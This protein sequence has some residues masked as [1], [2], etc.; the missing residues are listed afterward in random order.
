MPVKKCVD[1]KILFLTYKALHDKAPAYISDML[2]Y[3]EGRTFWSTQPNLLYV[4][5]TKCVTFGDRAFSV[6]AP[7]EWNKL[8]LEIRNLDTVDKFKAAIKHIRNKPKSP[9][10]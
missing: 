8:P 3:K 7:H 6:Y 1:F 4:P 9:Q 2:S 5:K 10:H